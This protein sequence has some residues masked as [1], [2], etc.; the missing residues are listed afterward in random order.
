L[1][2]LVLVL[3][4]HLELG[5]GSAD[6]LLPAPHFDKQSFL[7]SQPTLFLSHSVL[8]LSQLIQKH[9]SVHRAHSGPIFWVRDLPQPVMSQVSN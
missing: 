2:T 5:F 7:I 1:L 9:L 6:I 4:H 3:S 8:Y